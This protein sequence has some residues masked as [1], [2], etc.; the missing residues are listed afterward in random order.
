MDMNVYDAALFSFTLVEA[1]AIVLGN[2]LLVVTFI[3]HRAL[4]NAMNCYICSMCFSG[5]ITGV[6]VPL[7]FGN[8][9]GMNSIKLCS[10]ST[11]P[12]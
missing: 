3:R 7:G 8:Y 6:I 2:G 10:L 5:L 4:L 1:A 9:V 11:E 12:K